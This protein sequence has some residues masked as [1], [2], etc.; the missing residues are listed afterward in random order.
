MCKNITFA[1]S[2]C[3]FGSFLSVLFH[4]ETAGVTSSSSS[5]SFLLFFLVSS[6]LCLQVYNAKGEGLV[7]VS[8]NNCAALEN[9]ML[10]QTF[11]EIDPRVRPLGR[12]IKYWA[13]QRNINNRYEPP[14]VS[15][16][17]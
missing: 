3:D 5:L 7:D 4:C 9:S 10:I 11:G 6:S 16:C 14:R 8:V 17:I 13:K 2:P 1:M 15:A 12:F